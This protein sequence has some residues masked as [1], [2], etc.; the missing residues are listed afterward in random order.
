[1][2]YFARFEL[3]QPAG[4]AAEEFLRHWW[5]EAQGVAPARDA[6]ILKGLWKVAGQRVVLAVVDLPDHDAL[7]QLLMGLPIVRSMGSGVKAEVLPIR[8][9]E[10]FMEDLQKA[11]E[12][13]PVPA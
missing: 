5:E 8:P 2:L 6:G 13:S 3:I 12:E 9:Y 11:V 4:M 1:M 10:A 7:D